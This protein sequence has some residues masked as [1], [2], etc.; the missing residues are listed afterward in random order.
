MRKFS[1]LFIF[2][3][4]SVLSHTSS[5]NDMNTRIKNI[6]KEIQKKNTRIKNIDTETSKLEKNI[7]ILEKEIKEIEE[8]SKEIEVEIDI[9]KK[10]IDYGEKNLEISDR[11]FNKKELEYVA[12]IIAWDK[13][14]K[15]HTDEIN[16]KVIL[17]KNYREILHGDLQRMQ[18]I[19][20]V[21]GSIKEVKE[22][23]ENEKIKLDKLKKQL[24]ENIKKSDLKKEEHKKL[25]ARLSNEKK[26]HQSSIV[27][28]KK[29][30]ERISKE[31]E[32]IIKEN[33][34]K[35]EEEKKNKQKDSKKKE[36][37]DIPITNSEAYKKIGKTMQPINGSIVVYFKDKKAG[38][39]ESNGIEIKSK[40]GASVV[41]TKD[42]QV[43]YADKFQGLGKVV[44][45]DYG[46]NIIA[47]YGNLIAIKVKLNSYVKAGQQIG[48]LGLS[49]LKEPHLYYELRVNLKPID[50]LPTFK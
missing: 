39:V 29:E 21:S 11:E 9:V 26:G 31:I 36:I 18:H 15:I 32:R 28:L 12:K 44:M 30:K 48:V 4:F 45:I 38:L 42:G 17:K 50:P 22:K 16:D 46:N 13:F 47:V 2:L 5:I 43:I 41:S 27:K 34:R 1:F 24:L 14:S 10:N 40:V 7:K 33:I 20:A 23:I 3:I 35:K 49:S 37:V 25:I 19:E 6:D 8:D